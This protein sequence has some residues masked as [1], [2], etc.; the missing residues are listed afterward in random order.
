MQVVRI[1]E[2]NPRLE[3]EVRALCEAEGLPAPPFKEAVC[4]VL[5]DSRGSV[6]GAAFVSAGDDTC[7]LHAL[8][9]RGDSRKKG[10]G[11]ALVSHIL[12]QYSITHERMFLAPKD[13]RDF[14][15][16]FGFREVPREQVPEAGE[17]TAWIGEQKA[18]ETPLLVIDL[19]RGRKVFNI[20]GEQYDV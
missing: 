5:F 12:S 19:L 6:E 10:L 1:T 4:F 15:E 2:P 16:R 9:V 18:G 3:M 14:F 8:V 11:S 13:A 17:A 20:E 7:F